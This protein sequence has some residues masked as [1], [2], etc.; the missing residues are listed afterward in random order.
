MTSPFSSVPRP[1]AARRAALAA[2]AATALVVALPTPAQAAPGDLDP[3]FGDA[4]RLV[5]D[6]GTEEEARAVTVQPDGRIVAVGFGTPQGAGDFALARYHPDGSR[7]LS[8]GDTG[9]VFTDIDGGG[10]VAQGVA[11]QQ[12]G[13]IVVAGTS[14]SSEGGFFVTV[15]RYHPDGTPDLGFGGDGRVVTDFGTGGADDGTSVAVQPDGLIVVAGQS[16]GDFA[17]ARYNPDGT[18][19]TGFG[20]DGRVTADFDGGAD[21]ARSLAVQADG[22]IVAAG[23]HGAG[24]NYDFAVARYTTDGSLDTTF[25][26]DGRATV[27]FGATDM[28]HGVAVHSDGRIVAAGASGNDFAVARLLADGAPDPAFSGDG[29]TT[30]DFDGGGELA[31]AVVLQPDGRI[32]AGGNRAGDFALARYQ[33]DGSLDTGFSGDGRAVTDFG[34]G[35]EIA[36]GLALQGDGNIVAA[37]H[38]DGD[39]ALARYQGG[40]GAPL[41]TGADLRVTKS[42]P[43]SVVLGTRVTYTVTVTNLGSA[44]S[45]TGVTLTDAHTGPGTLIS[46]A[47]GQGTCSLAGA[48]A[49]CALGTLAPGASVGVSVVV[50]PSAAGTIGDTATVSASG[51]DPVPGNNSAGVTTTVANSRGCT[52]VGTSGADRLYGTAGDDVVC[53]LGGNDVIT[54]GNG[55]DT[56]YGGHGNDTV[57]GGYGADRLFGEAGNDSVTGSYGNDTL[58]TVDGVSG[59]DSAH[60]GPG[61]DS[62]ST[63]AGDTRTGCP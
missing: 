30:T 51:S 56:V 25:S 22:R 6:L 35:F 57:D 38:R 10:D 50:E 28:A 27:D 23:H 61:T 37:G 13:A 3:G 33:T 12:N 34:G 45:A 41:P 46:A 59:N 49:T 47:P 54:P 52:V 4:G 42:G 1:A 48:T 63:D 18:L 31:R 53:G 19:D 32:V 39:F 9:R 24:P 15:A 7:D 16:A 40:G 60:G 11:L 14:E 58:H 62:C 17:L 44:A 36:Y 8:F 2:A 5:S 43:T 20:T 55:N 26:A 21:A 29:R